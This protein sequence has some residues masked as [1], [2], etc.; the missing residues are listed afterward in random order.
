MKIVSCYAGLWKVS[1]PRYTEML[2][3]V[4]AGEY[5]NLARIGTR[6]GDIDLDVT[7]LSAEAA[8]VLLAAQQ[9]AKGI[10]AQ[11]ARIHALH[12][13]AARRAN[14]R[15]GAVSTRRSRRASKAGA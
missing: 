9:N 7:D 8:S 15:L 5:H 3:A 10:R 13:A 4:A 1:E 14:T 2:A 11:T 12:V 6:L